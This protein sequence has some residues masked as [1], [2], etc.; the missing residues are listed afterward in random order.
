[1]Q[2]KE[3]KDRTLLEAKEMIEYGKKAVRSYVPEVQEKTR[4]YF[5]KYQ[6]QSDK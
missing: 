3:I 2:E 4:R 1:M 5:L 6:A